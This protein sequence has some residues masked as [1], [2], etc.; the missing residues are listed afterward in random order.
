MLTI[1]LLKVTW[2][3][4]SSC[5]L[6]TRIMFKTIIILS[7]LTIV[8]IHCGK[9][10]AT[11]NTTTAMLMDQMVSIQGC[12]LLFYYNNESQKC[13]CLSSSV[14]ALESMVVC[15]NGRGQLR[16]SQ[17]MIYK[18]RQTQYLSVSVHTLH[19]MVTT[20]LNQASSVFLKTSLSSMTTCVDRWIER[21]YYAVS[22]L[23]VMGLQSLHQTSDVPS[24]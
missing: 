19:S 7:V 20:Y 2:T 8:T 18:R 4:Q 11:A 1:I 15:A 14:R 3:F 6:L 9:S 21:A 5:Y 16:Y 13:E 23:M 17:Y 10:K 22:V 12:P 24:V